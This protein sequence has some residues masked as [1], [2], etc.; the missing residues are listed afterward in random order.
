MA[1]EPTKK[2]ASKAAKK[3]APKKS[4][5]KKAEAPAPIP[6]PAPV[7]PPAPVV[8]K[9]APARKAAVSKAAA[10]KAAP[11]STAPGKP[12]TTIVAKIDIGFGNSLYLR[13]EGAGLSW[14]KGVV[15]GNAAP[16]E[17]VW[18]SDAVTSPVE[19]K[20][21]INDEIWAYGSNALVAAGERVIIEPDF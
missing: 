2:V 9:K 17:W 1:K 15:M 14:E 12:L 4:A 18:S 21:L 10:P 7:P 6:A 19:F 13:G 20:V 11:K 16:D 5:V 3:V 8:A